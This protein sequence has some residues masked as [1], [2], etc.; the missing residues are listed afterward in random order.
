LGPT[1]NQIDS[2]LFVGVV[3]DSKA[4]DASPETG[5]T[6]ERGAG[7]AIRGRGHVIVTSKVDDNMRRNHGG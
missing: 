5:L 2:G 4:R 1:A 6:T 3:V 7:G